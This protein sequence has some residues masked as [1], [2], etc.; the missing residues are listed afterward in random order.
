MPGDRK[1]DAVKNVASTS[2]TVAGLSA[3]LSWMFGMIDAGRFFVPPQETVG[4]MAA[5]LLPIY[6]AVWNRW[7]QEITRDY[8]GGVNGAP[9]QKPTT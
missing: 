6:Q 4:F 2:F 5:G 8:G 7:V 3:F 9:E 1:S